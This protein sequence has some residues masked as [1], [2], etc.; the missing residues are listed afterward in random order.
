MGLIIPIAIFVVLYTI[1]SAVAIP[2]FSLAFFLLV[3]EK[4]G[5]L[6]RYFQAVAILEGALGILVF[7]FL[8]ISYVLKFPS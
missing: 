4:A 1:C 2:I 3:R 6:L 5:L 8:V 7:L